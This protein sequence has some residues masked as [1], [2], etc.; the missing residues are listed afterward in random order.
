MKYVLA[1][2]L[3]LLFVQVNSTYPKI[4]NS[5]KIDDDCLVGWEN[6][7]LTTYQCVHKSSWPLWGVEWF[8]FIFVTFW[9]TGCLSAGMTGGGTLVPLLRMIFLFSAKDAILIS[10]ATIAVCGVINFCIS[11]K[12]THPLKVDTKGKPAG[13]EVEYDSVVI[14]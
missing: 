13:L 2:L 3:T 5:C 4:G 1:I 9:I 10:N 6:C 14:L 7:S 11:Y 12:R 8:G